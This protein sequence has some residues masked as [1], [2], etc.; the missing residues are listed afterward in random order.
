MAPQ[1]LR[2]VT[3]G[4]NS[5]SPHQPRLIMLPALLEHF[6]RHRVQDCDY[7]A[8]V[9]TPESCVRG[10]YV[11]GLTDADVG[12]LDVFE[13]YE[14][15]RQKVH[16]KVLDENEKEWDSLSLEPKENSRLVEAETYVWVAGDNDLD[17]GEWDFE[18]FKKNKMHRWLG[19]DELKRE[20]HP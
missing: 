16:V 1:L 3:R 4:S 12:R 13:G 19:G 5:P 10:T 14:Y 18:D 8:I 9:P 17:H 20:R 11:H 2:Q 6:A 7:P 15:V